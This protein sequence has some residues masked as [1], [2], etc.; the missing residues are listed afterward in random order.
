V[1]LGRATALTWREARVSV[2]RGDFI[3]CDENLPARSGDRGL[4][5][6]GTGVA[7]MKKDRS[8]GTARGHDAGAQGIGGRDAAGYLSLRHRRRRLQAPRISSRWKP[9]SRRRR[10]ARAP[11]RRDHQPQLLSDGAVLEHRAARSG[12]RMAEEERAEPIEDRQREHARPTLGVD[13]RDQHRRRAGAARG[14]QQE[15]EPPPGISTSVVTLAYFSRPSASRI[16]SAAATGPSQSANACA[17]ESVAQLDAWGRAVQ[18]VSARL[19][20]GRGKTLFVVRILRGARR[21]PPSKGTSTCEEL[22]F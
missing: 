20:H 6:P 2:A 22:A 18:K 13:D 7:R 1:L 16:H 10:R 9:C 11:G 8:G 3:L 19:E 15:S 5:G 17:S 12:Q 4:V 21:P 14:E